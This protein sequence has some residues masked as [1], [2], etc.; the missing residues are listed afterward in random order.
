MFATAVLYLSGFY[1]DMY[2]SFRYA[3]FQIV[4]TATTTGFSSTDYS[5]WHPSVLSL[6]MIL[7]LIGAVGGSTGG[8]IKI[9]RAILVYKTVK[10]ELKR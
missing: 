6:M 7:S 9:F 10:A 4:S 3:L 5:D 2:E 1:P 8:G